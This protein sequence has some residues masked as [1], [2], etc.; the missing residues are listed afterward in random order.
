LGRRLNIRRLPRLLT[1]DFSGSPYIKGIIHPTIYLPA[2]MMSH[3]QI[4]EIR[5]VLA[6]ELAHY[7]RGDLYWNW[8][9]MFV[10]V[11]FFFHPV[12]WLAEREWSE[13]QE[14]CC[15]HLAIRVSETPSGVYGNI[16]L[17]M[18]VQPQLSVRSQHGVFYLSETKETLKKR[19]LALKPH[20]PKNRLLTSVCL[21]FVSIALIVPLQLGFSKPFPVYLML[22]YKPEYV[23][24]L[25]HTMKVLYILYYV[26]SNERDNIKKI[27]LY[28]DDQLVP[29]NSL[30]KELFQRCYSD[31]TDYPFKGNREVTIELVAETET[32]QKKYP[33]SFQENL[34]WKNF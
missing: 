24:K 17:W 22:K 29:V 27:N 8:L 14:M 32:I 12:V 6:H 5:L 4:P 10:R 15:D 2:A 3:F 33:V 13:S 26:P 19:I 34:E 9:P 31:G 23:S 1:A 18:A 21:L 28:I 16:L 30:N 20:P 25:N 11:L 7:K